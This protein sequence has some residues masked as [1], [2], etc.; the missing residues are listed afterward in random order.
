MHTSM[1]HVLQGAVIDRSAG[2]QHDVRD[3]SGPA[4]SRQHGAAPA[5]AVPGMARRQCVDGWH[6]ERVWHAHAEGNEA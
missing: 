4:S 6:V 1:Y 5:E 3:R 2:P